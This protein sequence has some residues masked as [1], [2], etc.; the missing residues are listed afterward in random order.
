[1]KLCWT[2]TIWSYTDPAILL[3]RNFF[4]ASRKLSFTQK[5]T[6]TFFSTRAFSEH[7]SIRTMHELARVK[8]SAR[9]YFTVFVDGIDIDIHWCT[10]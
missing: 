1:M 2:E 4:L 3:F 7:L 8:Y 10:T 9:L 6:E 5:E